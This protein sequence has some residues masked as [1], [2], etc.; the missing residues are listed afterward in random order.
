MCVVSLGI[1][2]MVCFDDAYDMLP[3][4]FLF[5]IHDLARRCET[6]LKALGLLQ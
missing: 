4:H 5:F 1:L 6:V 3:C 2:V